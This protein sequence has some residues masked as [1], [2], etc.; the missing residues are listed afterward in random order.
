MNL[1][2]LRVGLLLSL[3]LA[4]LLT[5]LTL[6]L[7]LIVLRLAALGLRELRLD[8]KALG[9]A[10]DLQVALVAAGRDLLAAVGAE[11]MGVLEPAGDAGQT[12]ETDAEQAQY[13]TGEHLH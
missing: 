1:G 8:S 6:L 4:L 3:L 10:E 11:L 13:D 2:D 7:L 5:M 9:R 12:G